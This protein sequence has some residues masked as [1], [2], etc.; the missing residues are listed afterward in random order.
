MASKAA[1]L[2]LD[3]HYHFP[4][5]SFSPYISLLLLLI[6]VDLGF[7]LLVFLP[8]LGYFSL[9]LIVLVNCSQDILAGGGEPTTLVFEE[10]EHVG[11]K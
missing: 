7:V 5:L 1:V 9:V 6:F 3:V 8:Q 4:A 2:V 10:S 11:V